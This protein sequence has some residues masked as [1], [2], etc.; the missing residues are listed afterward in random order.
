MKRLGFVAMGFRTGTATAISGASGLEFRT[1][2]QR[3]FEL[4]ASKPEPP[5]FQQILGQC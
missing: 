1:R 2:P 4:A 5:N 3:P